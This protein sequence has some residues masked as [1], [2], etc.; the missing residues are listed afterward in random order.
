MKQLKLR[1]GMVGIAAGMLTLCPLIPIHAQQSDLIK[2]ATNDCG[3]KDSQPFLVSG[4]NYKLSDKFHGDAKSMTCNYGGK[5]IYAFNNLDIHADYQL[6]V[7]YLSDGERHQHIVVDGN[8]L[9]SVN[10][11]A[12][13]EQRHLI[14]LPRKA[15][16]YG[17]LVL[18]F[19]LDGNGPNALVSELNLYSSNP[20]APVPFVG[21][22][23]EAL[24]HVKAYKVNTE[25]D[26]E[27]VL[28]VYAA[29]PQ[30]V[31][32]TYQNQLSL[33]GNW[34]F[35]PKPE[36]E[37][38]MKPISEDW[39]SIVVPGQ[40]SM[41]GF[42]VDSMAYAGYRKQFEVP[43]D[44]EDRCIKLR[45][46]GVHSE[47][48]VFLNGTEVG[49]HLGGMTP[50]E[51][52]ITRQLKKGKNEVSLLVRSES[53]ADMLGSLTQ[54][55]VHQLGGITRKVTL[56][57]LPRTHVSELRIVTPLDKECKNADLQL[58]T[59]ITNTTDQ[60]QK[61]LKLRVSING[62]PNIL[63]K[64]LPDLAQGATWKGLLTD[65]VLA[66][67]L[68]D[69]EHPHLYTLNMELY[70]NGKMIERIEKRFGFRQ[71]AVQGD[72]VILNGKPLKLRGVCHH[73]IH[74]L[75][76]R[77]VNKELLRQDVEL[78]RAA[79]CNFIRTSHYP[80][81]E[82][83]LDLCDE[84][85]MFVE[86]ESP[87]CWIGHNANAN[88]STLNYRDPK[89][90]GYILQANME[91]IHFY[92]N[93]PSVVFWS[94]ANESCWNK[95]FAQVEEYVKKADPSRPHT[96]HDQAYG[97]FNNLGSTAPIANIHYPGPDG[98]KQA[99]KSSRPMIY[100][101]Y[102]HLNV[103]NR[104]ELVTDP[105]IRSDW[106]LAIGPTWEN[107]YQ[108]QGLLG[109]SIWSGIDDIFQ[110]PD[111]RACGYG[112]WG[113]ID[114]WRRPK[115]EYWD[116]KKVYSPIK[117]HTTSLEPSHQLTL[118]VENR[119]GYMDLNEVKIN[120]RYG[121]ESGVLT[122]SVPPRGR[123]QITVPI[124]HPSAANELYLSFTDPRGFVA[125]EYLIPVGR[126]VQN[127]VAVPAKVS[128]R[129]KSQKTHFVISG[130]NFSCRIN[131]MTGQVEAFQQGNHESLVGG[132][133]LMALPLVGGGCFPDHNA[134]TPVF[135]DIW[136]AWKATSVM[137]E[138]QGEDV[139]IHVEGSYKEFEGCYDLLVNAN[140]E[141]KVSY[142]FKALVDLNPRQWGVVFDSPLDYDNV[143]WRRK[144][145]WTVYP[146]DHI[147]RPVG[148]APLFYE[149]LPEKEDPRIRPCHSWNKDYNAMGSNDFR[150]TRRNIWYAGLT[151]HSGNKI[152]VKSN[153]DQHWRSWLEGDKIRFLIA[154]F[155]SPGN[156]MFLESHMQ[157]FRQPIQK[158]QII[159]GTVH[160]IISSDNR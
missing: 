131:R 103:Y 158:G 54:Y 93:H 10:L 46:D 142:R 44:W 50:F 114:G 97:G 5:V 141:V 61:D 74:P 105:G 9:H 87:V 129:L 122:V 35:H 16:A 19:E 45:F 149:G 86:V 117:V 154:D 138:K 113:P 12:G 98:Y 126:Q 101:E 18:I 60:L 156:E 143:F 28:P 144:G 56:F 36:K 150:S 137:A 66:P 104:R 135:N 11:E 80:P 33:N 140:G 147:G 110:L 8:E 22:E 34:F 82:E 24:R 72:Q 92:R 102:C 120:Y 15:Y 95:E 65:S 153:G 83:L 115:P 59:A 81:C 132:P 79:N 134:E 70:Q 125:D 55:A 136:S 88:W 62:L 116:M 32:G 2:V 47:Y 78:Y 52:D 151:D 109:G 51:V 76:G 157:R 106:A 4:E 30:A 133:Y 57:A 67:R 111:G 13:K 155:A 89:Y 77:V 128:T 27:K 68:W 84:L 21:E 145:L 40:W 112:A 91:T 119:Y 14:N 48:R 71:V 100:G 63:E 53:L 43:T 152:T 124:Q 25:V 64:N 1:K 39:K 96:F 37:F 75:M 17:Q 58:Q 160:L 73:E 31:N 49:A 26:V 3:V 123:G 108:T 107:M 29:I 41:Q 90:Y 139:K 20:K 6:E 118:E 7:V 146:E 121:N 85:G 99:A 148:E 42:A 69:N 38:Y 23:K 127:E 159:E 130:K 94:M